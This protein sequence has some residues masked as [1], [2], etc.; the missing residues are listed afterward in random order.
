MTPEQKQVFDRVCHSVNNTL[1]QILFL[2]AP[3]GTGKTFCVL[4]ML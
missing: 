4:T 2:D 1:G 3:G